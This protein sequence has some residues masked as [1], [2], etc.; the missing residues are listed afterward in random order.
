MLFSVRR[1]WRRTGNTGACWNCATCGWPCTTSWPARLPTTCQNHIVLT[2][3]S[4]LM[5]VHLHRNFDGLYFQCGLDFSFVT[6]M[7]SVLPHITS[8]RTL[9]SAVR[10]WRRTADSPCYVLASAEQVFF[11]PKHLKRIRTGVMIYFPNYVYAKVKVYSPVCLV[12]AKD[13]WDKGF[14]LVDPGLH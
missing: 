13:E 2:G 7:S 6:M 8:A 10:P 1:A 4:R 11:P 9:E 14:Q 5:G 3:R 12:R